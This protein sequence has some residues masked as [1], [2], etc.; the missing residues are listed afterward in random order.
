LAVGAGAAFVRTPG[1]RTAV[2]LTDDDAYGLTASVAE[3]LRGVGEVPSVLVA[4][5]GAAAV[6]DLIGRYPIGERIETTPRSAVSPAGSVDADADAGSSFAQPG[7]RVNLDDGVTIDVVDVRVVEQR[8]VL[9]LAV[10]AD[11]LVVWLPGPGRP[12]P[13][14]STMLG[15]ERTVL[16][17]PSTATAWLRDGPPQAWLLLVG[18]SPRVTAADLGDRLLLDQR[19]HGAIELVV[20]DGVLDVRVARC[21]SGSGCQVVIPE[22]AD[23]DRPPSTDRPAVGAQ[24]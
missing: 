21:D 18:Q 24:P 5:A 16:R 17:L 11:G 20:T 10:R 6:A 15:P 2:I 8:V 22:T 1:G 3:R 4:P 19:Q 14:W 12:S 7:T 9:D 13:G 23:A